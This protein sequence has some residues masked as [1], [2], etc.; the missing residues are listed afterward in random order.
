MLPRLNVQE[1]RGKS[2]TGFG[3]LPPLVNET[4][5]QSNNQQR[6][7]LKQPNQRNLP[8]KVSSVKFPALGKSQHPK[9]NQEEEENGR[10]TDRDNNEEDEKR[11]NLS[12]SRTSGSSR[13]SLNA[14]VK[15]K[16]RDFIK[17]LEEKKRKEREDRARQERRKKKFHEKMTRKILE[18]ADA[19]QNHTSPEVKDLTKELSRQEEPQEEEAVE[20]ERRKEKAKRQKRLLKKQQAHL[21]QIKAKQREEQ[22][23]LELEKEREQR[24]LEKVTQAVLTRIQEN[25]PDEQ[26]GE[27]EEVLTEEPN[28]EQPA[29]QPVNDQTEEQKQRAKEQR[30]SLQRK[31]QQYLQKLADQRKQ[32]Q[33]EEDDARALQEKRKRRIQKEAQQRLQEA[34]ARQQ[35]ITEAREKEEAAI[36]EAEKA[37]SV[38]PPVDVEA[39]VA[40]LSKLKERDVQIIPEARDFASWKKRHGVAPDQKVFCMTGWYPVI[41]EELEKRGWFYNQERVSPYFDFK[42]SLKSDELKAFKLEKNQFVNHFAQNA[43]ITTKVGLIHNLRSAVWHQSVDIDALFPRAYDL[44][45]PMYMDNFVQDFRYGVAEGLLKQLARRGLQLKN[46]LPGVAS[47]GANEALVDVVL[48]IARKKVKSKRPDSHNVEPPVDPLEESVDNPL[49]IGVDEL[50]TDLQWEV[51]TNCSLDKPGQLR[52]SLMY[53][54][55]VF[56]EDKDPMD[57]GSDTVV[58]AHDKRLQRL[59]DKLQ[60]DAFNREK[61]RL[62]D[63]I[64]HV[65]LVKDGAF[66]EAIRLA[67]ELEKLCPQFHIN[68]GAEFM[69]PD[70]HAAETSTSTSQNVWIVKPAG[71]SRGRGIRVFNDL[72]QLLEYV[73]VE[74]HK[75]CQWVAQ[76][77]IENPLLLCK[78]KFDIRQWVLVTGWDPLTVWFNDNCYLRFSSEEYSTEDLS[79]QYVHLTNNSIQKYSDK[80]NDVYATDDG[81]MQVEGN[82]WHSD[83]FKT[84]LASKMGKPDVWDTHMHPRMK[85]IVVQSLQCVQDMVQHRN[86]SCELYGYDFMVDDNLTPWLIEVNSSPA[87]DYSTP[88]A[89]R[90]VESGLS[91]IIK[92]VVDHREYEQKKRSGNVTGLEEPDT[93]CW[94]RIH[95]A[96]FVGKPMASFAVDFQVKGAKVQRSRRNGRTYKAKMVETSSSTSVLPISET[97]EDGE[98]DAQ[99]DVLDDDDVVED[100]GL[101]NEE[102]TEDGEEKDTN[103][104]D[105]DDIDGID[106]LL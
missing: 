36:A 52:A 70:I 83:D 31:Q 28:Q 27:V 30:D 72:D 45:D 103:H 38:G 58:S 65:S 41:R 35:L 64:A 82:M 95:K 20:T 43:A 100:E 62:S 37:A 6:S 85:E 33:K 16:N 15:D 46:K 106:P 14:P 67:Q 90:Y 104:K 29:Q 13:S 102:P 12:S 54:K 93:G 48:D 86:N 24:K 61:A 23:Q 55:K 51:L 69:L 19:R 8:A 81:E 84:F 53:K 66:V 87:C 78:R 76:K 47:M 68:G 49:S 63:L 2:P 9:C 50:V 17:E 25:R 96:E 42:W 18:K 1:G 75:E 79:D 57:V 34:A 4:P 32:K 56:A 99:V 71:M 73:D 91:G 74:N 44:N 3:L 7:R 5:V 11:Q 97:E 88:I 80:F 22:E 92:V 39:M 59:A 101:D 77:Y 60:T 21:A 10:V 94:Q 26:A 105:D 89:Q 98:D 40:R